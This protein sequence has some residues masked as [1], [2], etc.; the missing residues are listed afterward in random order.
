[1][2]LQNLSGGR[3]LSDMRNIVGKW[4]RLAVEIVETGWNSKVGQS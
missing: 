1:M 4:A 2:L 3:D